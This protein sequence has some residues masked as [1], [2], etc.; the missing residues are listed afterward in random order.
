MAPAISLVEVG[1]AFCD[2]GRESNKQWSSLK[3]YQLR[4]KSWYIVVALIIGIVIG[5]IIINNNYNYNY[6]GTAADWASAIM[7]FIAIIIVFWQMRR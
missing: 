5:T 7:S 2:V 3:D 1:G 4:E 6:L